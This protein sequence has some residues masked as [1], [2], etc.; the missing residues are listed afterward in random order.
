MRRRNPNTGLVVF[1]MK[2]RQRG[3]TRSIVGLYHFLRKSGQ[4]AKKLP[5]PK[6]TPKPYEPMQY[7][8]QRAQIDVKFVPKSC[9]VGE[10]AEEGGFY[11]HTFLNAG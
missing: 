10:A 7:S 5:N 4:M 11:Q 2:L 3:Y 6:Y 8:G 9:L 1:W